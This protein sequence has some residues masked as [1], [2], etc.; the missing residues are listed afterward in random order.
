MTVRIIAVGAALI[1]LVIGVV[2][3]GTHST[4]NCVQTSVTV[5]SQTYVSSSCP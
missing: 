5:G 3:V 2:I 1:A 4:G